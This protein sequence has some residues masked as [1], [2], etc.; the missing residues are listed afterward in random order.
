MDADKDSLQALLRLGL[1]ALECL[2]GEPAAAAGMQPVCAGSVGTPAPAAGMLDVASMQDNL[3][4][5]LGNLLVF[6]LLGRP[7]HADA[8]AAG[9]V[10]DAAAPVPINGGV[11][12]SSAATAN[13]HCGMEVATA[14]GTSATASIIPATGSAAAAAP[15]SACPM[16]SAEPLISPALALKLLH[17]QPG[18]LGQLLTLQRQLASLHA[19]HVGLAEVVSELAAVQLQQQLSAWMSVRDGRLLQAGWAADASVLSALGVRRPVVSGR[20]LPGK[21]AA[22]GAGGNISDDIKGRSSHPM[23][24]SPEPTPGPNAVPGTAAGPCKA[25]FEKTPKAPDISAVLAR[26]QRQ[27]L[28]AVRDAVAVMCELSDM[29][30][31]HPALLQLLQQALL[32]GGS[33]STGNSSSSSCKKG[34]IKH[35]GVNTCAQATSS[36]I[37]AAAPDAGPVAC[38]LDYALSSEESAS[39]LGSLLRMQ[40]F[41]SP[42]TAAAAAAVQADLLPL[43][44][45]WVA[46]LRTERRKRLDLVMHDPA[47]MPALA[48][49]IA[50]M[51]GLL[52]SYYHSCRPQQEAGGINSPLFIGTGRQIATATGGAVAGPGSPA[53]SQLAH[54]LHTIQASDTLVPAIC[55]ALTEHADQ[56]C[57]TGCTLACSEHAPALAWLLHHA[58][59]Y[60]KVELEQS[61]RHWSSIPHTWETHRWR[62]A[63][64]RKELKAVQKGQQAL[65]SAVLHAAISCAQASLEFASGSRRTSLAA[66]IANASSVDSAASLEVMTSGVPAVSCLSGHGCSPDVHGPGRCALTE[67]PAA[68]RAAHYWPLWKAL[69]Q[70]LQPTTPSALTTFTTATAPHPAIQPLTDTTVSTSTELGA[71]TDMSA[72]NPAEAP[73]PALNARMAAVTPMLVWSPD[74]A[75]ALSHDTI[76]ALSEARAAAL[77][78]ARS[79]DEDGVQ[80]LGGTA[81]A[82]FGW[83]ADEWE[84]EEETRAEKHSGRS[85]SSPF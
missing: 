78:A 3:L 76:A 19:P 55:S 57:S 61:I 7:L 46:R 59:Q 25:G 29:R 10:P 5:Q 81:F 71:D 62:V 40:Q 54:A 37:T 18:L 63:Q 13:A 32:P 79:G 43:L 58:M 2:S 9:A 44:N 26:M 49:H 34:Q 24:L 84:E 64:L 48:L 17:T 68:F 47:S 42:L 1:R 52:G 15:I 85:D 72:S 39:L 12:S 16:P 73:P 36:P 56:A 21:G 53:F 20:G 4:Q 50:R 65:H 67:R 28:P 14:P 70:Q 75:E 11:L 51:L 83:W 80:A 69:L 45:T 77:A 35:R 30:V 82:G 27:L 31:Q 74:L 22:S 60:S 8:D 33:S 66:A 6:S 38:P 23:V 41:Q